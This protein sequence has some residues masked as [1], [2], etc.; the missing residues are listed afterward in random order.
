MTTDAPRLEPYYS[1]LERQELAALEYHIARVWD[2]D[3][4]GLLPSGVR[5]TILGDAEARRDEIRTLAIARAAK[6]RARAILSGDPRVALEWAEQARAARPDDREAWTLAIDALVRLGEW[7]RAEARSAEAVTRFPSFHPAPE[8]LGRPRVAAPDRS[9]ELLILGSDDAPAI[10]KAAPTSATVR[11]RLRWSDLGRE[12][13]EDHWQKL[14]LCLAVLLIVVSS[15]LGAYQLLGPQVWSPIGKCVLALVYS[16]LFALL[17]VWLVRWGARRAGRIML[18]TTLIVVPA[19][20]MLIGQMRLLT[21]PSLSR[22]AVL[23]VDAAALFALIRV[24]AKSLGLP[25]GAGFLATALFALSAFNA[26]IPPAPWWPWEWMFTAFLAPALVLLGATFRVT[27]L[28]EGEPSEERFEATYFALALLSFAF[29]TGLVRAG[30]FAL[31]L[32]ATLY[33][34]PVMLAAVATARAGIRAPRFDPEPKHGRWLTFAALVLSG[35]G[36][37]LALAQPP[38]SILYRTNTLG[39]SLIALGLYATLLVVEQRPPFVYL[40]FGAFV[41]AYFAAYAVAADYIRPL[42]VSVARWLG[43]PDALPE[44]FRALNGLVFSPVLAMTAL[45]FRRRGATRLERHAHYLGVPLAVILCGLS[46]LET[47]AACLCL[48]G[49]A[50]LFAL[51]IPVFRAPSVAYLATAALAAAGY[52]G[53]TLVPGMTLADRAVRGAVLGLSYCLVAVVLRLRGRAQSP[54]APPFDDSALVM[55]VLAAIAAGVALFPW[56][57]VPLAPVLA[58]FTAALAAGLANRQERLAWAGYFT[59]ASA[60]AGYLLL[61][62]HAG[63]RWRDGLT[64]GQLA[65]AAALAGLFCAGLGR[66]LRRHSPA[67]RAAENAVYSRPLLHAAF[68]DVALALALC[69]REAAFLL[70]RLLTPAEYATLALALSL[71][72]LSLILL[73]RLYPFRTVAHLSMAC[74]LG[75]FFCLFEAAIGGAIAPWASYGVVAS[76]YALALLALE[77]SVRAWPRPASDDD[78]E[79]ATG[80]LAPVL[81]LFEIA[82]PVF[83]VVLVIGAV[84]LCAIGLRNGP[85]TIF[86]LGAG[87]VALLWTTRL[88]PAEDVVDLALALAV[89]AAQC[90]TVWRVGWTVPGWALSWMALTA[91]LSALAAVLLHRV[92]GSRAALALYSRPALRATAG[93]AWGAYALA[94]VGAPEP[95][96]AHRLGA[97]ALGVDALALVL[98]AGSSRWA[99]WTYQAIACGVT[100]VFLLVLEGRLPGPELMHVLGLT[101][102]AQALA[103]AALGFLGRALAGESTLPRGR[104][105]IW[106]Q[107]AFVSAL[108]LTA[109][110][111][112][113]A[114]DVPRTMLLAALAFLLMVKGLPWRSWLYPAILSCLCAGYHAYLVGRS[115]DVLVTWLVATA[116]VLWALGAAVRRT[117]PGLVRWLRLVGSGYALPLFHLALVAAVAA[118]VLRGSEHAGESLPWSRS[119]PLAYQ[120]AAFCVLMIEAWPSPAWMGVA[121]VLASLGFGFWLSPRVDHGLHW[122]EVAAVLANIWLVV[123]RLL[124]LVERPLCQRLRIPALGYAGP[125]ET[126]ARLYFA[127]TFAGAASLVLL[128]VGHALGVGA[129]L[130]PLD[131]QDLLG[132]RYVLAALGLEAIYLVVAWRRSDWPDIVLGLEVLGVLAVWWLAAPLSPLVVHGRLAPTTFLPAATAAAALV[133]AAVAAAVRRFDAN[134]AARL[135]AHSGR[136]G[137]ALAVVAALM[138]RGAL[139][140]ETIMTL[141]LAAVAPALRATAWRSIGAGYQAGA[142]CA[143]AGMLAAL[144]TAKRWDTTTEPAGLVWSALGLVAALAI[145]WLGAGLWRR[146]MA[147]ADDEEPIALPARNVAVA[148][149]QN[150]LFGAGLAVL[151]VALSACTSTPPGSAASWGA[152]GTL[153]GVALLGLGLIVRWG[154]AW[155][156]YPSQAAV[157]GCY[158][159]YRWIFPLPAS[160]DAAVLTA[161]GYLDFGLAEVIDRLGLARYAW[162]MRWF[163]LALPF[164]PLVL[165]VREVRS[166]D[167]QLF[168]LFT[169]AT[170]YGVAGASLQWKGLGYTAG[171]F[172]NSFLWVLWGRFGWQV[173]DHSQFYLIPVGLSA[174]L[175]AEFERATLGRPAANAVRGL[176]LSVI[177]L[178]LAVPVWQFESLGA[179]V[180]LLF[181]AL[182]GVFAGIGVRVQV[183]LWMGLVVFVLDVVYQLG[184]VGMRHTLA[185]WSIMLA[186]GI[187]LVF[188]VALN[189]KKRIV[190]RMKS[191][192]AIARQW[193]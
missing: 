27:D 77:D 128:S 108:I 72:G 36:L 117:E 111:V 185:K 64:P 90:F 40:S 129:D 84:T 112:V 91:A 88:R 131:S 78:G 169:V 70:D 44:P 38:G 19:N 39:A 43:Y 61:A 103:L 49:Y 5:A 153:A 50:V 151:L 167:L 83:E 12:F 15:N 16:T 105:Q 133:M 102:I 150:V 149:E 45:V 125:L 11:P 53:S 51:A 182:A 154:V 173:A 41:V 161:L 47:K 142:M 54:Y 9:L 71:A 184:K 183:F 134:R 76:F 116:Y 94:L 20:F 25:Y 152:I 144:T 191:L 68:A 14:I 48:G 189:E 168:V 98:L 42:I 118:G 165:L 115:I 188:F 158:L 21:E 146:M 186:L 62:L 177:Y 8:E 137:Q 187:L 138:T 113:L 160:T 80:G 22:L 73:A 85:G 55:S 170:F 140:V 37:A 181:L 26:A 172:Y 66:R 92:A 130:M 156:V 4:R 148:L 166:D 171:L 101:A 13:L 139:S 56:G 29:V 179:W 79:F 52:F 141:V 157:V 127:A 122:L 155:L 74:G 97:A 126:G 107:P 18:L 93:L 60:S 163:S 96:P 106:H 69:A 178:S 75:V 17:G 145:V 59:V 109:A 164:L 32:P 3:A 63:D 193:E 95:G 57:Y 162:P 99:A 174:V 176:G 58:L 31:D 33:A 100:A 121:F 124:A 123:G 89:A 46:M 143:A 110:A 81:R 82:V 23:A 30:V 190:A 86:T 28:A 34:L 175:V 1:P 120:L 87:A 136:A 6:Q 2:L 180:A 132:W 119:A 10:V 67:G 65:S 159:Y 104:E 7:D 135:D 147:E 192:I 35:V 24:V 114:Y